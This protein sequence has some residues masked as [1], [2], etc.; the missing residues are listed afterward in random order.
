MGTILY[1]VCLTSIVLM[2]GI[3][4]KIKIE[5]QRQQLSVAD[6]NEDSGESPI[7]VKEED[8]DIKISLIEEQS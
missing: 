5:N 2:F 6:R 8:N 7:T 4:H 3:Y 1:A